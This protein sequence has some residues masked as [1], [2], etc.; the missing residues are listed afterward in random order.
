MTAGP[1]YE[2]RWADGVQIKKPIE[3]SAPKYVEYIENR[4]RKMEEKMDVDGGNNRVDDSPSP[5]PRERDIKHLWVYELVFVGS[6]CK[7]RE[8]LNYG[9]RYV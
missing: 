3:V 9:R 1:K 5:T 7:G 8:E 2:Y 4:E 6:H